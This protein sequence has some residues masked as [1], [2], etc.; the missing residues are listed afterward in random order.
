MATRRDIILGGAAAVAVAGTALHL[1]NAIGATAASAVSGTTGRSL[2]K[3]VF[4]H[5]QPTA[6]SFARQTEAAGCSIYGLAD[7]PTSLWYDDLYHRWRVEP[8]AIAGMTTEEVALCLQM[9]A[10]DAGMRMVFRG[11]HRLGLDGLAE[12]HLQTSAPMMPAV[13]NEDHDW[14]VDIARAILMLNVVSV[15][16]NM[17]VARGGTPV[18]LRTDRSLVSWMMAPI[19]RA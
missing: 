1:K 6:R 13:L 2:Y 9:Y 3:V 8:V 10:E 4:D 16:S 14:S 15:P 19:R 7:D 18:G 5:R 17:V 12:H 11:D